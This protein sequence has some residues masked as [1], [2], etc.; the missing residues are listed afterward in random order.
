ML[1]KRR[2]AVASRDPFPATAAA[3]AAAATT[4]LLIPMPLL[5]RGIANFFLAAEE[6]A[7]R[8][9]RDRAS[10]IRSLARSRARERAR[11]DERQEDEG[12]FVVWD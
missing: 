1:G 3:A 6:D 5:H 4:A 11:S 8:E 2:T 10:E 7:L 12:S 9:S